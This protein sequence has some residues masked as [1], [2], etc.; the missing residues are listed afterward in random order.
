M[1][2]LC[3]YNTAAYN[4][5]EFGEAIEGVEIG[6]FLVFADTIESIEDRQEY[7]GAFGHFD[8]PFGAVEQ[9]IAEDGADCIEDVFLEGETEEILRL[10]RCLE[11]ILTGKEALP[12][13]ER[14]LNSVKQLCSTSF[15]DAVRQQAQRVLSI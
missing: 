15:D 9:A 5:V 10:L 1:E 13:Q 3:S 12:E 14:I 8:T 11:Q 2:G 4:E 7:S 6:S